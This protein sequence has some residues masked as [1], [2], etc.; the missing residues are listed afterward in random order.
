MNI[1]L[2]IPAQTGIHKPVSS[3]TVLWVPACAGTT[4]LVRAAIAPHD[5][6]PKINQ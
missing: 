2:V 4:G 5:D 6:W 1:L 3:G